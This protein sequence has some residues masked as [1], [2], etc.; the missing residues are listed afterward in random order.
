MSTIFVTSFYGSFIIPETET[1]AIYTTEEKRCDK[2]G[3]PVDADD[4]DGFCVADLI[5]ETTKQRLIF[6]NLYL[7]LDCMLEINALLEGYCCH[8]A[9]EKL[10]IDVNRLCDFV[11]VDLIGSKSIIIEN[12]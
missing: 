8:S 9:Q 2:S 1:V 10:H 11:D 6:P 3:N 7:G 4:P 5:F 12:K